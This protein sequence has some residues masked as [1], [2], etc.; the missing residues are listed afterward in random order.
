MQNPK[1]RDRIQVQQPPPATVTNQEYLSLMKSKKEFAQL[2]AEAL[3]EADKQL[4][5]FIL[6]SVGFRVLLFSTIL[7]HSSHCLLNLGHGSQ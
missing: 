1:F 3:A 4:K 7:F 2:Y 5:V 6:I